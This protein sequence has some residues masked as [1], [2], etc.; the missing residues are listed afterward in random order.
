MF[1]SAKYFSKMN[2][3]RPRIS[4]LARY[5]SSSLFNID[6][7]CVEMQ[8]VVRTTTLEPANERNGERFVYLQILPHCNVIKMVKNEQSFPLN[9]S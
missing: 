2:N 6:P 4:L 3:E 9:L 1:D 5:I 7:L 8:S